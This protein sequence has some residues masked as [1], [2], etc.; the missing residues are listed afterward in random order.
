MGNTS[1]IFR[2]GRR[3]RA[4]FSMLGILLVLVILFVLV[5]HY[6]EGSLDRQQQSVGTYQYTTQRARNVAEDANLK[7]LQDS[8]NIWAMQ[9]PG[10]RCAI[11]KLQAGGGYSVPAPP[12]GKKYEID[13]NN[14]AMLVEIQPPTPPGQ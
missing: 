14:Q 13:E 6:F 11:E 5:G 2:P 7:I 10:E 12:P 3:V 4:G 9:H 1:F 8:V